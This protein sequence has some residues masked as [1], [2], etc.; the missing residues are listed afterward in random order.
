MRLH[1]RGDT[2]TATAGQVTTLVDRLGPTDQVPIFAFDAS[3]DAPG[4][5][6]ASPRPGPGSWCG[7]A[8]TESSTPIPSHRTA[9]PAGPTFTGT[10]ALWPSPPPGPMPT[11][12]SPPPTTATAGCA[13]M[14]GTTCIPSLTAAAIG[15]TKRSSRSCAGRSCGWTWSTCPNPPAASRRSAGSGSPA[16]TSTSISAGA[17][18]C[19]ASTHTFRFY[20]NTLGWTA[21]SPCTPE[22]ADR[23]TWTITAAYT[24]LRLARTLVDDHRRPW[25]R[26]RPR[27]RLSPARIRR[28]FRRLQP[29]LSPWPVRRNPEPRAPGDHAA[30]KPDDEPGIPPSRQPPEV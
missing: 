17:P 26:P 18:T 21:P 13:S 11:Q 10:A 14:P 15:R 30:P 8:M 12:R 2:T 16:P 23:W 25:E 28:R 4:L 7:S 1:P 20:K 6:H 5:T 24:Q 9:G 19:A 29:P 22:Q 3:Y 27:P